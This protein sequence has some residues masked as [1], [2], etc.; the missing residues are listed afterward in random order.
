MTQEVPNSDLWHTV[1]VL[2]LIITFFAV[3]LQIA[4]SD[5]RSAKMPP[6]RIAL[7]AVACGVVLILAVGAFRYLAYF[8]T[9]PI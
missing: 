1:V 8:C 7:N 5:C 4:Y 2:A 6:W 3:V 9:R